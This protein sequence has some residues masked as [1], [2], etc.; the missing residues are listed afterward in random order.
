MMVDVITVQLNNNGT[1][2]QQDALLSMN[3]FHSTSSSSSSPPLLQNRQ[4][5]PFQGIHDDKNNFYAGKGYSV[6]A[7]S[8]KRAALDNTINKHVDKKLKQHNL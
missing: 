3:R 5:Y 7:N 1:M 4:A 2:E 8:N 6:S